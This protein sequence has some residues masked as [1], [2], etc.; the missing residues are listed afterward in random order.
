MR[1]MRRYVLVGSLAVCGFVI[2]GGV[3]AV[4]GP[5]FGPM[6]RDLGWSNERIS[7]LATAYTI[8]NLGSNPI[9]GIAL[10]KFGARIVLLLGASAFAGGL[11]CASQSHSWMVLTGCFALIGIGMSAVNLPSAVVVTRSLPTRK[12]LGLGILMGAMAVGGTVFLPLVS[13]WIHALGWRQ[14][15]VRLAALVLVLLPMLWFC[16]RTEQ[17]RTATRRIA[18]TT[19]DDASSP[20]LSQLLSP[21]FLLAALSGLLLSVGMLGIYYDV[22]DLLVKAGYSPRI[23]S[24]AFGSTWLLSG[25]GSLVFGFLADKFGPVRVLATV[26]L[27]G[28]CGTL[29][30]FGTPEPRY[31]A[32]CLVAF[33]LLWGSSANGFNQLIP[34]VLVERFGPSRLGTIVGAQFALAGVAGSVAPILTGWLVDRSGNYRITIAVSGSAMLLSAVVASTIGFSKASSRCSGL[35]QRTGQ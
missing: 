13:T 28:G 32:L 20:V 23:A 6:M 34:A 19:T 3:I 33:I 15:M 4:V 24:L 31:G 7:V 2:G 29:F 30:L 27:A 25:A 10:D 22:V 18:T 26:I 21:A 35:L 16:L 14:A 1:D 8:G 9:V 17:S 11:L 12:G 5:V